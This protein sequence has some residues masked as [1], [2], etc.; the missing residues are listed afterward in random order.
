MV[1]LPKEIQW[2]D[3]MGSQSDRRDEVG[4]FCR[5]WFEDHN[6]PGAFGIGR[7]KKATEATPHMAGFLRCRREFTAWHRGERLEG[8][9]AQRRPLFVA[10]PVSWLRWIEVQARRQDRVGLFCQWLLTEYPG[11]L[12]LDQTEYKFRI[13]APGTKWHKTGFKRC[14]QEWWAYRKGERL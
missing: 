1:D 9:V 6:G 8:V 2:P 3:W 5:W 13:S 11:G 14:C 12:Y 10:Q 4:R 7:I